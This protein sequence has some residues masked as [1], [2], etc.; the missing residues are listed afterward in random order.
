MAG[1]K[2][3]IATRNEIKVP[4]KPLASWM[5]LVARIKIPI[6]ARSDFDCIDLLP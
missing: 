4:K 6:C 2:S 1:A 5:I 3:S